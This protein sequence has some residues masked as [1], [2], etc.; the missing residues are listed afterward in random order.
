MTCA[1]Q[2]LISHVHGFLE[3]ELVGWSKSIFERK[4]FT[5]CHMDDTEPLALGAEQLWAYTSLLFF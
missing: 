5:S 3:Y 4:L 1:K 2:S